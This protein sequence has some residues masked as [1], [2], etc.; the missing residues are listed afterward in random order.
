MVCYSYFQSYF[1]NNRLTGLALFDFG[2]TCK[3]M[4][5]CNFC[6]KPEHNLATLFGLAP[7]D[8]IIWQNLLSNGLLL[9]CVQNHNTIW[10]FYD[11]VLPDLVPQNILGNG[12][13]LFMSKTQHKMGTPLICHSWIKSV[14]KLARKWLFVIHVQNIT[15]DGHSLDLSLVDQKC[16][17]TCEE[18]AFCYSYPNTTRYGTSLIW[19]SL[20]KYGKT[21]KEM[22]FAILVSKNHN[23]I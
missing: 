10:L 2:K 17:K 20:I 4:G 6:P 8:P 16:G 19:H 13:L 21:C 15:Q 9:I 18:M 22:C 14:A 5:D 3:E 1:L 23:T 11:S 12:L 7:F